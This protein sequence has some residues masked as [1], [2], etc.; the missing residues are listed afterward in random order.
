MSRQTAGLTSWYTDYAG[1]G[2]RGRTYFPFPA[3][4]SD[5]GLGLP[6]D[7]YVTN[8]TNLAVSLLSFN[9]VSGVGGTVTLQF[10]LLS[11]KSLATPGI[12]TASITGFQPRKRWATMRKRG[13]YGKSNVVPF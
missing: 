13:S 2:R 5:E 12:H 8:M 10:V 4:A 9:T 11:T 3:N 6:T 7:T 1:P